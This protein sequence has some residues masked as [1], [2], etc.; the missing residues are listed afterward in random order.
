MV[1]CR[2]VCASQWSTENAITTAVLHIR[3]DGTRVAVNKQMVIHSSM[4]MGM[5]IIAYG[6][7]FPYKT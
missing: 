2:R 7:I 4:E 5:P 6:Q 3:Q 1:S